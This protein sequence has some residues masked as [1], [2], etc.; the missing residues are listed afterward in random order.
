MRK[1]VSADGTTLVA[2]RSGQG[3]PVVLIHGS[4]GGLDSWDRVAPFLADS[5]EV[6]V[7]ARRGYAPSG[8]GSHA[9]TFADDVADA[10][11]VVRA[12]GDDAHLVGASYG[13]TVGLH[14]ARNNASAV[15]SLA[16]FEP[17]LFASGAALLP[18]LGS[19]G[20]LIASGDLTG[21]ARLFAEKVARVPTELLEALPHHGG[22]VAEAVGC[23]HDL[24]AMADDQT[25]ITRWRDIRVPTLLMQG[26]HSWQPIPSTMERLA[27]VLPAAQ[28]AVLEGQSHFA[29]HTA[30]ELFAEELLRFLAGYSA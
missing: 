3:I 2:H 5:F 23:L 13:G 11:A 28:R 4:S 18:V 25:D 16:L 27:K 17:P 22:D 14:L 7:Y 8:T 6:W 29:T 24:E 30:H 1:L 21:A 12:A 20:S 15:R 10:L 9:K 19:Y 26:A